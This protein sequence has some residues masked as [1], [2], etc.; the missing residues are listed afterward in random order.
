[1]VDVLYRDEAPQL[2][3]FHRGDMLAREWAKE[4][5]VPVF[6]YSQSKGGSSCGQVKPD[7]VFYWE[8][9]SKATLSSPAQDV[10]IRS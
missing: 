6:L 7:A 5:G 1:M 9:D 8:K 10:I 3:S 4:V 2:G